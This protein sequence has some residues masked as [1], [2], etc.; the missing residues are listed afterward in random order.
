MADPAVPQSMATEF[1]EMKRR[2]SSL[3]RSAQLKSSSIKGGALRVLDANGNEIFTAGE[4]TVGGD[5]E[6]GVRVQAIDGSHAPASKESNGA[7]G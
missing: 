7:R 1:A 5:D 2:I 6:T 3:E 4:F